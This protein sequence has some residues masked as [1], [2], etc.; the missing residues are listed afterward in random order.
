MRASIAG[1][2]FGRWSCP[3]LACLVGLTIL[4][5]A[6]PVAA[7]MAA[8]YEQTLRRHGV[9]PDAVGVA[10]YLQELLLPAEQHRARLAPLLGD[11]AS[12]DFARREAAMQKLTRLR[13][14]RPDV[15]AELTSNADPEA[16]WRV[17]VVLR[18]TQS[19]NPEVLHAAYQVI[20]HRQIPGLAPLVL[21]TIPLCQ[22]DYA[23]KP[24]LPRAA[25]LALPATAQASDAARLRQILRGSEAPL[26]AAAVEALAS[27]LGPQAIP[28]LYALL[29]DQQD[30]VALAAVRRLADVGDRK[31][32]PPLVAMLESET[33]DTRVHA[34]RTLRGLT[35]LDFNFIAYGTQDKQ[36]ADRKESVGR[37]KHWLA[38]QSATAPLHFPLKLRDGEESYLGGNTLLACGNKNQVIELDPAG[39][40]VWRYDVRGCWS[41]EK[42]ANGNVLI[43]AY[44]MNKVLEVTPAKEIAW[45]Y[46]CNCL[47]A[48]PLPNGNVLVADYGGSRVFEVTREKE[49]V[50]EQRTTG[51]CTDAQRLENGNTLVSASN[52]V[53]EYSPDKD[54]VWEYSGGQQIYGA[55][56]L[57][58]GNTL[59]CDIGQNKVAEVNQEQQ[60]VWEFGERYPGDAFRLS[61]GNTLITT[62]NRF[63]EVDP[64]GE[65][66][67]EKA[68]A[69]YGTARR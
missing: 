2:W 62:A 9:E 11:L 13:V 21:D 35:G 61:N 5:A 47:N 32:L 1:K 36:I 67:W 37:W 69:S 7:Q 68:E 59:T 43:A 50:W 6:R 33:V 23:N 52:R 40:E 18:S 46:D 55:R 27:A 3:L 4:V 17:E 25:L 29:E 14:L 19:S 57:P 39:N 28:E 51:N 45:E 26:R 34:A 31:C 65:V 54:V 12:D 64:S 48:K 53:V 8:R 66:V 16:R 38:T 30:P 44:A 42:M 24:H 63:V 49:I 20:R 10:G 56:R 58:N 22:R 60:I 15:V 41:A